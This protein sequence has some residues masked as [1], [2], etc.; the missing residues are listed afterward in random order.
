MSN[1]YA[2]GTVIGAALLGLAKTSLLGS[3]NDGVRVVSFEELRRYANDPRLAPLVTEVNLY[4]KNLRT[5]PPEIWNLTNLETLYLSFNQ[6]KTLPPEIGNL[7][8]L[9]VLFL[10][11]NK[12]TTL[13]PKIGKL[14]NLEELYLGDNELTT[15]PPEIGNLTKLENLNLYNN[16]NLKIT[17]DFVVDM[18]N[19]YQNTTLATILSEYIHQQTIPARQTIRMR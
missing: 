18:L 12:L 2:I 19:T 4:R 1:K 14:K 9:K 8:N 6:I 7:T 10:S 3:K 15:L 5:L 11:R 17:L 13:P 16:P